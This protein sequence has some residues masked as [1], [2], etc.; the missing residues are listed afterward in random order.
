MLDPNEG[1]CAITYGGRVGKTAIGIIHLL[2]LHLSLLTLRI[3]SAT[4]LDS[5]LDLNG[6]CPQILE[7]VS[8]QL[9]RRAL[10]LSDNRARR[11]APLPPLPSQPKE[12]VIATT[13]QSSAPNVTTTQEQ[14]EGKEP[15]SKKR[16]ME[17]KKVDGKC[18]QPNPTITSELKE[19]HPLFRQDAPKV[20]LLSNDNQKL[21]VDKST[22]SNH[23][24]VF[25]PP[26]ASAISHPCFGPP[27]PHTAAVC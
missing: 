7:S 21:C 26:G 24:Q 13:D 27:A 11:S 18:N 22:L 1:L 25:L 2:F 20:V 17:E 19:W 9:I 6:R 3:L 14:K 16:K 4:E 5:Y 15:E 10:T 23:R 12:T 8:F